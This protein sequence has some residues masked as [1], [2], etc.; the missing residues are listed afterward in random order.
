MNIINAGS[1][2][3]LDEAGSY[4]EDKKSGRQIKI[5]MGESELEFDLWVPKAG[6]QKRRRNCKE[7]EKGKL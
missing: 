2:I 1:R 5:K 3:I 4:I 7:K 6:A